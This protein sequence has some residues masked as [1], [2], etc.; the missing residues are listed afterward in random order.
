MKTTI[1][2]I[3]AVVSVVCMTL[4]LQWCWSWVK[5]SIDWFMDKLIKKDQQKTQWFVV[6]SEVVYAHLNEEGWA[7]R[8]RDMW[9]KEVPDFCSLLNEE[10]HEN[11]KAINL[12]D[13]EIELVNQ[14]LSCLT[15]IEL[16]NISYN[17][18]TAVRSL[19]DI[20]SLKQLKLQKNNI[21]TLENFPEFIGLESLVLSFNNLKDTV[22][23]EKL[24][25]LTNLELAHNSIENLVGVENLERLE[26][27]K[28]EF[29]NIR[30]IDSLDDLKNL[31]FVSAARNQLRTSVEEE[32][33]KMNQLFLEKIFGESNTWGALET[34]VVINWESEE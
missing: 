1:R 31:K 22:W 2:K 27:L 11:I 9:L 14:D 29:N 17:K 21:S 16:I 24:K 12:Q 6:T 8:M 26:T 33:N 5:T 18:V 32:L 7:I 20:P 34:T 3:F 13:N 10:D 23:L 30:E 4:V 25:N 28:I 15:N 19:G